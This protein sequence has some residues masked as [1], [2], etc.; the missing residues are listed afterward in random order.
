MIL[1]DSPLGTDV[2]GQEESHSAVLSK[3]SCNPDDITPLSLDTPVAN[4][5]LKCLPKSAIPFTLSSSGSRFNEV[6]FF[7]NISFLNHSCHPNAQQSWNANFG[8]R[9]GTETVYALRAITVGEE[10][11]ISYCPEGQSMGGNYLKDVYGFDC[12]CAWCLNQLAIVDTPYHALE[13]SRAAGGM[14]VLPLYAL[15]VF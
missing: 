2:L 15:S 7:P 1:A 11:T 13:T 8:S 5:D 3:G 10:I 6:G 4:P 12:V 14:F 9:E